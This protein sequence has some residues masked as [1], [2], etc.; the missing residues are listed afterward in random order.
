MDATPGC[1]P[2]SHLPQR[3]NASFSRATLCFGSWRQGM[4]N[5]RTSGF[6]CVGG[7]AD[8][9]SGCAAGKHPKPTP[10]LKSASSAPSAPPTIP[11]QSG[12]F[13]LPIP[14]IISQT[15]FPAPALS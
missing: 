1:L 2:F 5:E 14:K 4:W 8:G 10:S 15:F 12:E 11:R 13:D 9:E 3:T 6:T 7:D